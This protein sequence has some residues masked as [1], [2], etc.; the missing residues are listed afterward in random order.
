MVILIWNRR[1]SGEIS[2]RRLAEAALRE[3]QERFKSIT[4]NVPGVV[5]RRVMTPGGDLHYPY[6]SEGVKS[7]YGM[8]PDEVKER[9]QDLLALI[10]PDDR[11]L[12]FDSLKKSAAGL[13]SWELE[14]R[15]RLTDGSVRWMRGV[16]EVHKEA[17]GDIVW[18]GLI[19]DITDRKLAEERFQ[20]MAANVP[21]CLVQ[22][23]VFADG[24]WEYQY[25]SQKCVE[26][27]GEPP[28]KV[29][30]E[31]L[32]L[33][34]HPEDRERVK[35]EL[36]SGYAERRDFNVVGRIYTGPGELKWI[37]LSASPS[38]GESGDLT[39]NGFI[40]DITKRKLAEQEY[41]ASERK[42]SAMSQAVNDAL[43]MV[44]SRGKVL[45]WNHAAEELFGY[46]QEEA[47]GMDYH[48]MAAPEQYHKSIEA[49]L[50]NFAETGEGPVLGITTELT[51]RNRNGDEFPV[52]VTLSSFQMD[53]QWF[54][55]G[56]VRDITERKRAE[57]EMRQY[58][59]ELERFHR[60]VVG[61]EEKMIQLKEEVNSLMGELGKHDRYKIVH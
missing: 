45:F 17:S 49:G 12:F 38:V 7:I 52:E 34:W 37:R 31:R 44:D 8:T 35:Q 58:V 6:I 53:E 20:T 26:F 25:L 27:Y 54:S 57:E 10:H 15:V 13:E 46:S 48:A 47:M 33:N 51:A 3:S 2:Q 59:D 61:R 39:Y 42:V 5:Y 60:L 32:V 14:F 16:S 56:V 41:L 50:A 1:L 22:I 30:E 19:L 55:T 40:L 29:I 28:D 11:E 4:S 23:K 18:D 9:P 21:G 24:K 43:V 36:Q